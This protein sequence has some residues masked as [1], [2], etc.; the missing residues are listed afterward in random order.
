MREFMYISRRMSPA[1]TVSGDVQL[2]HRLRFG[3]GEQRRIREE[4]GRHGLMVAGGEPLDKEELR[5]LRRTNRA[6]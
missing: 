1:M 6:D 4:I 2:G 5:D 3:W